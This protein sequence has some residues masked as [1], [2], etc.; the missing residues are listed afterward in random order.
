MKWTLLLTINIL[1]ISFS[2]ARI[3]INKI[4]ANSSREV[5]IYS[6]HQVPE[7][8]KE[9]K[10]E[11]RNSSITYLDN[12]Y[13]LNKERII[14]KYA[15]DSSGFF[16]E[17]GSS[18]RATT[19]QAKKVSVNTYVLLYTSRFKPSSTYGVSC[20]FAKDPKKFENPYYY[21]HRVLEF[22]SDKSA[23]T[24]SQLENLD[25]VGR[26]DLSAEELLREDIFSIPELVEYMEAQL[27]ERYPKRTS[28]KTNELHLIKK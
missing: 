10:I 7:F 25:G 28:Y 11:I 8:S 16:G 6:T 27:N 4:K 17:S 13:P 23:V 21:I 9:V 14:E 18:C 15:V 20:Y 19:T 2:Q 5:L 26:P 3:P 12:V 24:I 1:L 22:N